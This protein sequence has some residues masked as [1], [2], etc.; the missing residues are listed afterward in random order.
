MTPIETPEQ[1]H[2]RIALQ[3]Y[4]GREIDAK[5]IARIKQ[6]PCL[7]CQHYPPSEAAHIRL[8]EFAYH[9][10]MA[11]MAVK[12]A[13]CMTVPLCDKHHRVGAQAEHTMGTRLF[14]RRQQIEPHEIAYALWLISSTPDVEDPVKVQMMEALLVRHRY[15]GE[16]K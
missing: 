1:A 14:W 8:Q 3:R 4:H 9:A 16:L 15:L 7:I 11:G 13:D 10:H 2:R 6:L 5:H 12:P